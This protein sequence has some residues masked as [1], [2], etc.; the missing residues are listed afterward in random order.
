MSSVDKA[1]VDKDLKLVIVGYPS[2][3]KTH[4]LLSFVKSTDI[5]DVPYTPI[6]EKYISY[7]VVDGQL[8]QLHLWDTPGC[9][10]NHDLHN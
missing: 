4:L 6:P 1:S 2:S 9:W 10:L 5:Y 8:V 7:T 3:G